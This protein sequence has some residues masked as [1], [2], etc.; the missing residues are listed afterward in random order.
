MG[1]TIGNRSQSIDM[2]DRGFLMLRTKIAELLDID[3]SVLYKE[4]SDNLY[5][6]F[7]S[8]EARKKYWEDYNKRA[9]ALCE[10][11]KLDED[12][13][14]FLY[15]SDCEG[16]V[17]PNGCHSLYSV[18]QDYDD[19]ICYGYTGRPDCAKF[20][21]FKEIIFDCWKNRRQLQWY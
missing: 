9:L 10:E 5:T 18:I 20:K 3:F 21:D 15:A 1:I 17:T 11:K 16:K 13:V 14:N 8:E 12:V 4:M 19:D 7:D 6:R 2:G